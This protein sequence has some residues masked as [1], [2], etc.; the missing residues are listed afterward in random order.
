[1][2]ETKKKFVAF[3]TN[4]NPLRR[5]N[6]KVTQKRRHDYYTNG[7]GSQGIRVSLPRVAKK[8]RA[9]RAKFT[10]VV[11][12]PFVGN[13]AKNQRLSKACVPVIAAG[14]DA[15][16]ALLF[17]IARRVAQNSQTLKVRHLEIARDIMNDC[18]K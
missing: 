15:S 17:R 4:T 14:L 5:T 12:E 7:K 18:K 9:I 13:V 11:L 16:L 6:R 2:E 8:I 3:K 10:P 1:M